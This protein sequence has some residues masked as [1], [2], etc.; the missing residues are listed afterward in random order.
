[1]KTLIPAFVAALL[2]ASPVLAQIS[3]EQQA[4][5]DER[6]FLEAADLGEAAATSASLAMAA[7]SLA[8][9]GYYLAAEEEKQP[10]F[11]RAVALAERAVAEDE[12]NP[13]AHFQHSHAM[14]RYAQT[15]GVVEALS[16]GYAELIRDAMNKALAL[17]PE[18][19]P[20]LLSVGTWHAEIVAAAGSLMAGIMYDADEEQSLAA[21][22]KAYALAPEHNG[23][24]LEYAIGLIL[25]D[26]DDYCAQTRELLTAA[27]T[28]PAD[29]AYEEIVVDQAKMRLAELDCDD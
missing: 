2:A 11:V 21:Y 23:V 7:E 1:M 5:F 16:D 22:E 27:I 20:A 10:L 6:R 18:M 13:Q 15:I 24:N 28:L 17:D 14:G 19:V 12:T 26:D 9:H 4:A 8:L 3:A 25:L 29:N